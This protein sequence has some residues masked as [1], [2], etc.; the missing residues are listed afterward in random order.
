M[1]RAALIIALMLLVA[2]PARAQETSGSFAEGSI[3]IGYDSRTCNAGLAGSLRYNSS[4]NSLVG[5]WKLDEA[6]GTSAAD[7]SGN[8]NTGT[9]HNMEGADWVA[10]K[11]GSALNFSGDG[12]TEYV[13]IADSASLDI[14]GPVTLCAWV[15]ATSFTSSGEEDVIL[16]KSSAAV[17]AQYYLSTDDSPSTSAKRIVF[18]WTNTAGSV[19]E[20]YVSTNTISSGA[21]HHVCGVRVNNNDVDLYI[22]GVSQTVNVFQGG[23]VT[24]STATAPIT[25]GRAGA[26]SALYWNGVIDDA[27]VYNRDLSAQEIDYLYQCGLAGNCSSKAIEFCDGASWRK[28]GG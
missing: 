26:V 15:N 13:S 9:L 8:S 4:G 23:N 7:S 3:K 25:L 21:W 2:S 6:S 19:T 1:K 20:S 16:G 22:N 10:G 18:G 11:I 5:Y 12:T 27:R 28:W 14:P 24:P 17:S